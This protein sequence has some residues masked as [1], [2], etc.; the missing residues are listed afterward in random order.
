MG[1]KYKICLA[2]LGSIG[3]RHIENIRNYGIR[4]GAEIHIDVLRSGAGAGADIDG[5]LAA[6][7]DRV[8]TGRSTVR[9][10][11][12]AVF[13]TNPTSLHYDTLEFFSDKSSAFFIEKPVFGVEDLGR[14]TPKL[15]NPELAYVA[16]P[17]RY[18]AVVSAVR[19]R[20]ARWK[21]VHVSAICSSYLP[22]WRSGTDYRDTYSAKRTLGG[23]VTIDLIHEWDYLCDLFGTPEE[24]KMIA[25]KVSS[26]EIDSDDI[27]LYIAKYPDMTLELHLDYFGRAPR[28]ELTI[29]TDEDIIVADIQ[30][31]SLTRWG[32]DEAMRFDNE[33]N[34]MYERE[35]AAFFDII[36]GVRVN[37][38]TIEDAL[39]VM[40][41]AVG[42]K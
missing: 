37:P 8:I 14:R 1:V 2:G 26:L 29:Y 41:I 42:S 38:N 7:I 16:C 6:K 24:V 21:A 17:L 20:L 30:S 35:I 32:S 28:R 5:K 34:S 13:I 4:S 40:R 36:N 19:E 18:S 12:D 11:Y 23:G 22:D 27:A 10:D 39:R 33:R 3:R 9:H 15:A 31:G 25:A